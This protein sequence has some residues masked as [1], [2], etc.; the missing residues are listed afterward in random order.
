MVVTFARKFKT[1]NNQS[2]TAYA[3]L[4]SYVMAMEFF[5]SN[6]G[7]LS[8]KKVVR[9]KREVGLLSLLFHLILQTICC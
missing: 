3:F 6:L 7:K 2:E 4:E 1:E 8:G 9:A 5:W